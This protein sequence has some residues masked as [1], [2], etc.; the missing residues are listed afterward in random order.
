MGKHDKD[1]DTTVAR[2]AGNILA[3][4]GLTVKDLQSA[5]DPNESATWIKLAVRGAVQ[6]A[7][8]ITDEVR[9]V[10]PMDRG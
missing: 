9:E 5:G 4:A 3:G 7:K 8:R 1:Y 6:I 10:A 2:A